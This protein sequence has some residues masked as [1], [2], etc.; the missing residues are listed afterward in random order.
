M[1]R[2]L[3]FSSTFAHAAKEAAVQRLVYLGGLGETGPRLSKLLAS[4]REVEQALV[5]AGVPVTVHSL[6]EGM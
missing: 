4:R 1:E 2:D 5:S 3:H 6:S